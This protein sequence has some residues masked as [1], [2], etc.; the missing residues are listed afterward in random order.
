MSDIVYNILNSNDKRKIKKFLETFFLDTNSKSKL[1]DITSIY[2]SLPSC[3]CKTDRNI[4]DIILNSKHIYYIMNYC[5]KMKYINKNDDVFQKYL[6]NSLYKKVKYIGI[7]TDEDKKIYTY[8]LFNIFT[9]EIIKYSIF[10]DNDFE[11]DDDIFGLPH[12]MFN[13]YLPSSEKYLNK[14]FKYLDQIGYNYANSRTSYL[15]TFAYNAYSIYGLKLLCARNVISLINDK[16][17]HND[18]NR[19]FICELLNF[20]YKKNDIS[21]EDLIKNPDLLLHDRYELLIIQKNNRYQ[22]SVIDENDY[23]D[24]LESTYDINEYID[25]ETETIVPM[26]D[27]YLDYNKLIKIEYYLNL[28]IYYNDSLIKLIFRNN[29]NLSNSEIN[30]ILLNYFIEILKKEYKDYYYDITE[31][32]NILSVYRKKYLLSNKYYEHRY[33]IFKEIC[34]HGFIPNKNLSIL[35]KTGSKIIEI[36][37]PHIHQKFLQLF[38]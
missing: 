20:R 8:L 35:Y 13:R 28:I 17:V 16:S 18:V 33:S 19:Q 11:E 29:S 15:L 22:L 27:K 14:I 9:E 25:S 10:E 38:N 21:Y 12:L 26:Y 37:Y 2:C 31:I 23:S 4:L 30:Q 3:K 6:L 5:I 36:C 24:E 7:T 1:Y 34:S 32:N